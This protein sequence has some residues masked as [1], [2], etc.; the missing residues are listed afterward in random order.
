MAA[1]R[2][3]L[4]LGDVTL[5]AV[6]FRQ[7][8]GSF[9][10]LLAGVGTMYEH[11]LY[12]SDLFEYLALP[13]ARPDLSLPS[14]SVPGHHGRAREEGIR[15]ENVG[16]RYAGCDDWALQD[17]SFEIPR[18]TCAALAGENGAGKTTVIK[19]LCGLYLPTEGR[20]LLDGRDLRSWDAEE[21]RRRMSMVFQDFNQYHLSARENVGVGSIE[22]LEDAARIARAVDH[23]GARALIARLPAGI[24]TQLGRQFMDG[25]ELSGGEWQKIAVSRAFMREEADILI[26]DEPTAALD[27]KAEHAVFE[28]FR[29]LARGKTSLLISHRF[30]TVRSADSILFLERGRLVERGNHVELMRSGARYAQLF[31]LQAGGYR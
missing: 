3:T 27:A 31:E 25:V 8:S 10:G 23:G 5:Y 30:S 1:V 7:A 4:S 15:F 29:R 19:L 24:D 2:G 26:L 11:N 14:Q 17:V 12:M 28:R 20:V 6:A 18:G 13:A 21:L 9:Q 22:H 16:F